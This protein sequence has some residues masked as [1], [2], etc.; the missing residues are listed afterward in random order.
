MTNKRKLLARAFGS[1]GL[2]R[3]LEQLAY[4]RPVLVILTYHRIAVP[5]A[6]Q[7][8]FYDPV[9]S[10][11]PEAFETQVRFLAKR[12]N[13]L[14]LDC[15]LKIAAHEGGS[16]KAFP[17][18]AKPLALVTF[19]DGYRDNYCTALPILRKLG[20][21]AT[22]FIPTQFLSIPG[23][24]WWDHVA[25]VLKRTSIPQ[26]TLQRFPGDSAPLIL[27]LGFMA[28][29]SQRTAAITTV[30]Q[31]LLDGA[32][33]DETW[34]LAQLDV[35]AEVPVDRSALGRE[36][37]MTLDQLGELVNTGMAVGSHTQSHRVLASLDDS[38][39]HDELAKSK[40]FLESALGRRVEAFA[41]PFGR[42]GTFTTR[43]MQL[44]VEAGYR[45]AFSG[46]E[47]VN[48]PLSP[49]FQPVA[50]RRLTVGTG[51]SPSLL[52]AR[53]ALHTVLGRSFL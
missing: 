35:Q 5:G 18:V 43:T 9:V 49:L 48:W 50:L 26:L 47:G 3:L 8:P 14:T 45:L 36:L 15:L 24:P 42:V 28:S 2:V 52:R 29:H 39:Q 25:Y 23:L 4:E 19:D 7:N 11:T 22:F 27:N 41:Y 33:A 34:F 13:V 12:F 20:V 21:P 10:A 1:L 37:F 46:V 6:L 40:R 53:V 51:D 17:S 16:T 31:L 44:V 38:T 30:I 32:I